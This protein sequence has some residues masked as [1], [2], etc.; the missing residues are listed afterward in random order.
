MKDWEFIALVAIACYHMYWLNKQIEQ[1]HNLLVMIL[2]KV[3]R[4]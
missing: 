3:E 1:L 2:D 4:R